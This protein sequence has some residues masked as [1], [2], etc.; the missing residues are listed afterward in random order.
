MTVD[1]NK[2]IRNIYYLT[3]KLFNAISA[4]LKE[5]FK[6]TPYLKGDDFEKCLRKKVYKKT[7][8]DLLMK[9][10]DF[11]E[12][13][14]DFIESSLYPDFLFRDKKSK[15]VFYV[16][17]KYRENTYQGKVNWCKEHQLMRYKELDKVIP[18]TIA[19]GL[20][21]RPYNPRQIFL[22]PLEKDL[23]SSL[24]LDFLKDYEFTGNRKNFIDRIIDNIYDYSKRDL[25]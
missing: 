13:N 7:D 21:G 1:K 19:I 16:E 2:I 8:H 6:P 3:K 4:F 18:I 24:C 20:G 22:I 10:H 23:E 12:N 11:Q 17:A 5:L 25:K 9:T 14:K 15:L